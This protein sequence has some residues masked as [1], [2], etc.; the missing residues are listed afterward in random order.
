MVLGRRRD[1][2]STCLWRGVIGLL[3]LLVVIGLAS[4]GF[5]L[6]LRTLGNSGRDPT[7]GDLR[8]DKVDPSIGLSTLAGAP[9]MDVV[10]KA[11]EEDQVETAYA[12]TLFST[13]LSDREMI[14]SLLLVGEA[15]ADAGDKARA[16]SC[17]RQATLISTLSPSLSDSAR[18]LSLVEIGGS[19]AESG[20]QGEAAFNYDQ[21]FALA[22]YSPF[23][24]DPL[25]ADL[26]GELA[27][28]YAS[29]GLNA[30]AEECRVL[31]AEIR[32]SGGE[33]QSP[34]AG[35]PEQ[36]VANFLTGIPSPGPAM[37][38]SY[39]E[40]RVDA[41]S[42]LM[43]FLQGSS[44]REAVPQDLATEVTQALV[45][46]DQARAASYEDELAGA[47]SLVLRIGIAESR[48]DWIRVKYR[49][50][51]G[52]YGLDLVP[53]WSS[54]VVGV[55][56][57]LKAAHQELHAI[58]GEQIDT[59][60]DSTAK[61]RAWFDVLRLEIMQGR[62]GLYPDSPEQ[63]LISELTEVTGRL[64]EAGDTSLHPEVVYEDGAPRFRL[65]WAD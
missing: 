13:Q 14:G 10:N 47:S 45:N 58:Y 19:L 15:Y 53:A 61:D 31:E 49:I 65:A 11:L 57:E 2:R 46:E 40:R 42:E 9:D 56:E 7:V 4:G 62:L 33:G 22:A 27:E 55:S 63:E 50:A 6:Y 24:R 1:P 43:E 36:P 8:G 18:A 35:E 23:L 25:R 48:V 59:F 38:A 28:E 34:A 54:D 60:G 16:Q 51:L 21:A 39:T 30:K 64:N 32:Y 12:T 3:V 37:V 52:G 44:G 41:I 5:Y 17:Y 26:L 20:D 29:L